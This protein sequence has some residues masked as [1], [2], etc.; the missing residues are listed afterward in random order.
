[1]NRLYGRNFAWLDSS[2]LVLL[3]AAGCSS[4]VDDKWT[5]MRPPVF[6]ATG[7]VVYQDKPVAGATVMLESQSSDE[8]ARGKVA[9]GHTDSGG[10]FRVRTYKEYEGAV[11]GLHRI[12]VTKFE[13]IE[14]KPANADPNIDYPLI[15]KPLLP[16]R[17]KDFETSG[18]TATVTEQ[19]PNSFRL[20]LAE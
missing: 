2:A 6:P 10:R 4:R 3:L 8:K 5:R 13:Y 12:T 20:E 16:E 9:I 19:G 14:N 15:A 7:I 1:M 11:A 17:Y 18:L